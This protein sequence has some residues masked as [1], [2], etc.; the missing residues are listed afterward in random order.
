MTGSPLSALLSQ[1]LVAFTIEFDNEFEHLMP[2]RTTSHGTA[3]GVPWL[4]SM[5]M[6]VHCM[7]HVAE[8]GIPA[9]EL[10]RRAQLPPKAAEMILKRMSRW[11]GYLRIEPGP[12]N[13]STWLVRPT[14]AGREAQSIWEPLT[15]EITGRWR[16]RYGED[17][18]DAVVSGLAPLDALLGAS[19][20]DF[21]PIGEQSRG[22]RIEARPARPPGAE[23]DPALPALVSRIL[24]AYALEF[25]AAVGPPI[26]LSANVLRVLSPDGMPVS[27]LPALTGIARMGV[28]NSLSLLER[29]GLLAT[30]TDPTGGRTRLAR[31]TAK[32]QRGQAV[33]PENVAAIER[34]W[35]TRLGGQVLDG[36]RR[37][38]ERLVGDGTANGSPLFSA[39]EPYPDG[40]RAQV[41]APDRLPQFPM[42]SHRG[43]FPDG[44]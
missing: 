2:H 37:A 30:G 3:P 19:A 43:G 36:A 12:G 26:A 27:R 8:D 7:R 34:D 28:D 25:D 40:W 33:Y 18:I 9:G 15:S 20:P 21:L 16:T 44:S 6:W 24:Y 17:D 38:L 35:E 23:R 22:W 14:R 10:A 29:R 1:T 41:R 32:G 5:A 39:L 4:V 11:W 13:E 42:V 31:L